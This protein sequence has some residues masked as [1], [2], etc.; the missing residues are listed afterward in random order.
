MSLR[1]TLLPLRLLR[2]V[3]GLA[4]QGLDGLGQ[5]H[6]ALGGPRLQASVDVLI[7][8]LVQPLHLPFLH[9]SILTQDSAKRYVGGEFRS[10]VKGGKRVEWGLEV[11]GM[12]ERR[13]FDGWLLYGGRPVPGWLQRRPEVSFGAKLLYAEIA[14]R[15]G[16][17]SLSD[18]A[19]A[20]GASVRTIERLLQELMGKG[21]LGVGRGARIEPLAHSWH[22]DAF[23]SVEGEAPPVPSPQRPGRPG[24]I[25]LL[26]AENGLYKIGMAKELDRRVVQIGIQVPFSVEL[27][28]SVEVRDRVLTEALYHERFRNKRVKGEWFRLDEEDLEWLKAHPGW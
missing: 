28:H 9:T 22:E 17:A 1:P 3:Q 10:C 24:W 2:Q 21:L 7:N 11:R 14:N 12:A 8:R 19:T 13:A 25:Y 16:R 5:L 18:L 23:Y 15:E 27:V 20:L 4:Q 6:P 26:R